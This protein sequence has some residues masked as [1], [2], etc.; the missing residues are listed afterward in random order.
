M[1]LSWRP[2]C[3]LVVLLV[4]AVG[5]LPLRADEATDDAAKGS[6][7]L[8]RQDYDEA[9]ADCSDAIHL[10]PNLA[11][12]FRDRGVAF[13]W[14]GRYDQALADFKDAIRLSSDSSKSPGTPC[15]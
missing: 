14:K 8:A 4:A 10:N 1:D 6:A 12:A 13:R 9:I 5:S 15:R 7:A 2:S 11:G 3:L